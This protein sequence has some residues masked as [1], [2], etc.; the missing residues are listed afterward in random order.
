MSP[1]TSPGQSGPPA[2]PGAEPTTEL[3][4]APPIVHRG[5]VYRAVMAFA[6]SLLRF[7]TGIRIEGLEHLPPGA[8]VIAANHRSFVDIPM[9]AHAAARRG[10]GRRHVCFLARE[11]L[12]TSRLLGFIMRH[13]GCVLIA[14]G[15]PDR[16]ALRDVAA[17]LAAGDLVAIFPEGTR[18]TGPDLQ[19]FQSGALHA[20][21]RAAVPVIPCAIGGS[22]EAWP[23]GR[24]FPIRRR[25]AILFGPAIDP[26]QP[27]ALAQVRTWLRG[28]LATMPEHPPLPPGPDP[29]QR[30]DGAPAADGVV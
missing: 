3:A 11:T 2:A 27:D 5:L 24:R 26:A 20:A 13:A 16:A 8:A 1:G 29:E 30:S 6:A 25:V 18:G 22:A 4:E 9:I 15:R 19:P 14:R 7:R 23:K 21:R 17:H 28:A 12:A 10:A